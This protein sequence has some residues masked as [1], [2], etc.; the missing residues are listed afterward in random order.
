[1]STKFYSHVLTLWFFCNRYLEQC[2]LSLFSLLK[3]DE[4]D[5]F[6]I[7]RQDTDKPEFSA[8]SKIPKK[9]T[10]REAEQGERNKI[11]IAFNCRML[12]NVLV[13]TMPFDINTINGD[14]VG[15]GIDQLGIVTIS[16]GQAN[17]ERVL[18]PHLLS[19]TNWVTLAID[20]LDLKNMNVTSTITDKQKDKE[21]HLMKILQDRFQQHLM[22]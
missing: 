21:D 18:P 19:D 10:I 17:Q 12:K 1:M 5:A 9:G 3:C 22:A 6:I 14:V 16:L 7:A 11:Q 2:T 13:D 4:L 15:S 20:L 8:K